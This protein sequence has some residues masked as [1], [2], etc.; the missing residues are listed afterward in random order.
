MGDTYVL[1]KS[2]G[3]SVIRSYSLKP[4]DE[5]QISPALACA[6]YTVRRMDDADTLGR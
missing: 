3:T 1:I 6:L 5:R 4:T 2:D